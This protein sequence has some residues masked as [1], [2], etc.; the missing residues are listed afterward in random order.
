MG[1]SKACFEIVIVIVIAIVIVIVFADTQTPP[2][3]A[4]VHRVVC[5]SEIGGE[6]QARAH[7][8]VFSA[9]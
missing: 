3:L 6:G 9:A 8:G 1:A 2:F 5:A 7:Q 4:T